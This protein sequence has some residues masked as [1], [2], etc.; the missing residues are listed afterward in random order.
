MTVQ[1]Y[2]AR[3]QDVGVQ[4][5]VVHLIIT[6][7]A[8]SLLN[9]V[10]K[11]LFVDGKSSNNEDIGPYSTVPIYAQRKQFARPGSYRPQGK[12]KNRAKLVSKKGTVYVVDKKRKS[13][14]L[15]DGYKELRQIQ[16]LPSDKV[17]LRYRGRLQKSYVMNELQDSVILGLNQPLSVLIKDRMEAKY[18]KKLFQATPG[19]IKAY[20][21]RV[22]ASLARLTRNT[23]Q[24]VSAAPLV[25]TPTENNLID[26]GIV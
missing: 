24:G 21:D 25:V 5:N 13:M 20:S 2:I 17:N 26:F 19:E 18:K 11:R 6:P 14:Y 22:S 12:I 1:E 15:S 8:V 3:L 10:K 7:N 4:G 16:S 23:L 9:S